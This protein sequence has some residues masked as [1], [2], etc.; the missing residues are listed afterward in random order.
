M[1]IDGLSQADVKLL[2]ILWQ[3]DTEDELYSWL[4]R[5]SPGV[6]KRAKVLIEL[7]VMADREEDP[8]D[9]DTRIGKT[10]LKNIGVKFR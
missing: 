5:Q 9:N 4:K 10:M 2:D 1:K 6:Q 8:L 7:A 3:L